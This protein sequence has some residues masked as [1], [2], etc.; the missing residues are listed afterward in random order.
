MTFGVHGK[1]GEPAKEW[2]ARHGRSH[3][4]NCP[5]CREEFRRAPFVT[6]RTEKL[7]LSLTVGDVEDGVLDRADR[8]ARRRVVG[9]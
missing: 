7:G 6:L 8:D 9:R 4:G 3:W 5:A 2:C 1:R